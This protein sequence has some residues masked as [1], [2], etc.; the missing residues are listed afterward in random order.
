MADQLLAGQYPHPP[1]ADRI[2]ALHRS[3]PARR[4]AG[5]GVLPIVAKHGILSIIN[6]S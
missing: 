1:Q 2:S 4:A 6:Y 3:R 5:N